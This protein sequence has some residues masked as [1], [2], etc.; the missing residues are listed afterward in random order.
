MLAFDNPMD[1]I[2]FASW[3]EEAPGLAGSQDLADAIE[4]N[5]DLFRGW[6]LDDWRD[7]ESRVAV[8][9][10]MTEDDVHLLRQ[11]FDDGENLP[12]SLLLAAIDIVRERA[13]A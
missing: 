3:A 8:P 2:S 11:W 6:Q 13:E 9:R 7:F 10:Q 4:N 1:V 12:V 5:M